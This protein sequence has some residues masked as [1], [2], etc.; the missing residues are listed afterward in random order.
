[1][2][3]MF[4]QVLFHSLKY[5]DTN[6]CSKGAPTMNTGPTTQYTAIKGND[7]TLYC[8]FSSSSP[9]SSVKWLYYKN[10]AFRDVIVD[11]SNYSGG[12][13]TTPSL[14][15]YNVDSNDQGNYMCRVTN[16][17]GSADGSTLSL[18]VYDS[19]YH[20]SMGH[21]FLAQSTSKYN[22]FLS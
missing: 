19:K 21:F 14:T 17:V 1:M 9:V 15:I 2:R 4:G 6:S 11:G 22:V 5:N 7:V 16:S 13:A 20:Y 8:G 12:S 10:G 3:V 18:T